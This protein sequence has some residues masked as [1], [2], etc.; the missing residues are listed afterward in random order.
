MKWM[1]KEGQVVVAGRVG[2]V[3]KKNESL[4]SVSIAN[5]TNKEETAWEYVAFTNPRSGEGFKLA[6]LAGK[7]IEIGQYITAVCNE[8]EK[9]GYKN[10]YAVSVELGPKS[11]KTKE[12]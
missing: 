5:R 12:A 1:V 9:D 6:D 8:I 3:D 10:L 2:R 4:V 11:K 7:Y